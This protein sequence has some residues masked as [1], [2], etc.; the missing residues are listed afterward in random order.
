MDLENKTKSIA[1][2]FLENKSKTKQ[3]DVIDNIGRSQKNYIE[4]LVNKNTFKNKTSTCQP[5]LK[6]EQNDVPKY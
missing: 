4:K 5:N 1:L 2:G 6:Y 3:C